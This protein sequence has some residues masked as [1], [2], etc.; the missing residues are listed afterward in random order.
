MIDNLTNLGNTEFLKMKYANYI[1]EHPNSNF[2]MIDLSSFKKINDTYGHEKGDL[3]LINFSEKLKTYFRNALLI[4]LHGDEFAVVTCLNEHKIANILSLVDEA[5]NADVINGYLP[6]KFGFNAGTAGCMNNL[7]E[8]QK[9]ADFMMYYAK[10]NKLMYQPFD[11]KIYRNRII[12]ELF[13]DEF[14]EKMKSLNFTY[15]G[16]N[17]YDLNGKEKDLIQVYTKDINGHNLLGFYYNTLRNNNQIS[18]FDM[19]NLRNLSSKISM[20][21]GNTSYFISIDYKSLLSVKGLLKFFEIT[22]ES[23]ISGIDNIIVSIDLEKIETHEYAMTLE[24]IHLLSD[25]GFKIRLE[26]V[27]NKI[28][29]Y[30][31]IESNPSYIKINTDAWKNSMNN[32]RDQKILE[33]RFNSYKLYGDNPKIL[34]EKIETDEEFDFIRNIAPEDSL[35]SGNKFSKEKRLKLD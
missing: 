12:E 27:D 16:R 11:E 2:I 9:K 5:I 31:I 32:T 19:Y 24:I 15:Y 7:D 8:T 21:D 28:A 18:S 34:F 26:K 23:T 30:I 35:V 33:S 14:E 1:A 29:D 25:M 13:L 3:C 20:M 17:I 22:K 6:L 10:R 4:R